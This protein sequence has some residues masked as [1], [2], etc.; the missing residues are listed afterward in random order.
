MHFVEHEYTTQHQAK[1]SSS[2][3]GGKGWHPQGM[4]QAGEVG[5]CEKLLKLNKA[6]HKVLHLGQ[7]NLR[8]KRRLS[9]EWIENSPVEKGLGNTSGWKAGNELAM[10]ACNPESY[11]GL[12]PSHPGCIKISV[13]SRLR[14]VILTLYFCDT[15]AGE[16]CPTFGP[17]V[18]ERHG[19][20]WVGSGK[21][22]KND[23]SAATPLLWTKAERAGVC[24]AWGR[25]LAASILSLK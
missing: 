6:E 12:S 15:P 17:Q 5:S 4:L 18:Q 20:V 19:S 22:Q 7:C 9:D 8:P 1:Q 24:S 16:L 11:Q 25:D 10:C 21:D 13:I 2:Y 14:E 3:T 23:Q